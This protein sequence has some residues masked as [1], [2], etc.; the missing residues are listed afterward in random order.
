MVCQLQTVN[1]LP[2]QRYE[3]YQAT[4]NRMRIMI[5]TLYDH[6][7]CELD[8]CFWTKLHEDRTDILSGKFG[9]ITVNS[10]EGEPAQ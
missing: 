10:D 6:S 7:K 1:L 3:K 5:E 4:F 8:N 9:N 2:Y